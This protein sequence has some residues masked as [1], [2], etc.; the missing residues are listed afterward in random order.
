MVFAEIGGFEKAVTKGNRST[1]EFEGQTHQYAYLVN[2]LGVERVIVG[3]IKMGNTSP[4]PCN[5][6]RFNKFAEEVSAM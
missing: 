5:Q 6:E 4:S 1:G 2:L 3:I